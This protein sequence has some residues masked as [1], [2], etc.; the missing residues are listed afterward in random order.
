MASNVTRAQNFDGR[1]LGYSMIRNEA[2]NSNNTDF[3]ITLD[4]TSFTLI[5]SV[6][7]TKAGV[8]FIAPPSGNV[9]VEFCASMYNTQETI[10][11]GLSTS[12]SSYAE[13]E[14]KHTYDEKG[15]YYGDETDRFTLTMKWIVEGLT[16]G[17]SATYYIWYRV[18]SGTAYIYHG[19]S[20]HHSTLY[21]M[22]P[23]ITKVTALPATF[24]ISGD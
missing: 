5:E 3:V 7:G 11:F 23:V 10:F 19:E 6:E 24:S 22:P 8:T 2:G 1:I 14:D 4:Q 16:P 12:N 9:E 18:G 13:V 17:A 21:H 20:F 15:N